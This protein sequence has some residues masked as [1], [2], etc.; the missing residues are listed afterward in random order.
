MVFSR[1]GGAL[2]I[3]LAKNISGGLLGSVFIYLVFISQVDCWSLGVLLYAVVYGAMPFDGS[4]FR[5]LRNQ[6]TAGE[7][8]KPNR[9]SGSYHKQIYI[10]Q[11]DTLKKTPLSFHSAQKI[12]VF[13]NNFKFHKMLN[14]LNKIICRTYDFVLIDLIYSQLHDVHVF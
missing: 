7:Y 1:R 8:F 2:S 6:I 11:P 4:D 14:I 3:V 12:F 13:E 5:R 9:P 10:D